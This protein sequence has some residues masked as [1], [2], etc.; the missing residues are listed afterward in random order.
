[1]LKKLKSLLQSVFSPSVEEKESLEILDSL[2]YKLKSD[3]K[4]FPVSSWNVDRDTLAIKT[5]SHS[6][7]GYVIIMEDD[8]EGDYL[9]ISERRSNEKFNFR[10]S[11]IR[12]FFT[13]Y[14]EEFDNLCKNKK[15]D[16]RK[17]AAKR[18]LEK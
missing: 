14:G 1:M 11:H 5:F 7:V 6:L 17:Q 4:T 15:L 3:L 10:E 12:E 8:G 16:S 13:V 18:I 9:S 2:F